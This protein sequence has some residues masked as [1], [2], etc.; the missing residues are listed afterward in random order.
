MAAASLGNCQQ[1]LL[2]SVCTFV[3]WCGL[4][5]SGGFVIW[6]SWNSACGFIERADGKAC[7][8]KSLNKKAAAIW[9]R[10]EDEENAGSNNTRHLQTTGSFVSSLLQQPKECF[11]FDQDCLPYRL[12]EGSAV[13]RQGKA[14]VPTTVFV[15]I[16]KAGG[17]S[18]KKALLR[19]RFKYLL[20]RA[21]VDPRPIPHVHH[22]VVGGSAMGAC[23]SSRQP[24]FYFTLMRHPLDRAVSDYNYYGLRGAEGRTKWM[25]TWKKCEWSLLEWFTNYD[26]QHNYGAAPNLL[27]HRIAYGAWFK[28]RETLLDTAKRNLLN[29]CVRFLLLDRLSNGL[30]R[31]AQDFHWLPRLD[32]DLKPAKQ[33]TKYHKQ[34]QSRSDLPPDVESKLSDIMRLDIEL[35]NFAVD[36]Y[37]RQWGRSLHTCVN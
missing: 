34:G 37:E 21:R 13:K 1:R 10:S 26:P 5:A 33:N 22:V 28:D 15:H 24:C 32:A 27:V 6:R 23:E 36:H 2:L 4:S 19:L 20:L 29:G 31:L 8:D 14:S 12:L 7:P 11:L 25:K 3:L 17:T 30:D 16:N 35:Y 9:R 18:V